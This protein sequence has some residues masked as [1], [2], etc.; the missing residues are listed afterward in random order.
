M[1]YANKAIKTIAVCLSI[2]LLVA[3]HYTVSFEG[4]SLLDTNGQEFGRLS[5][6]IET[7]D[8]SLYTP[9]RVSIEPDI[10]EVALSGSMDVFPTETTTYTMTVEAHRTDGTEWNTSITTTVYIGPRVDYSKFTDSKLKACAE[11]TGYTHIEQFQSLLCYD[12]EIRSLRG[13]EQLTELTYLGVDYNQI[14]NFSP[15]ASLEKLSTLSASDNGISSV[16]AFPLIDSLSSLVLSNN[17]IADPSPLSALTNLDNLALDHNAISSAATLSG[18]T[19][20][21]SLFLQYNDIDDVT[22]LSQLTQL[23]ALSLQANGIRYGV[24]SLKSLTNIAALDMRDNH[25]VSCLQ[26]ATLFLYLGSALLT[27]GCK[28]P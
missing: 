3:C 14:T 20:L 1:H 25:E 7:T 16:S 23:Q 2:L 28:F 21:T 13:I 10:G 9:D 17:N 15:L 24:P 22:N 8:G 18:F 12:K 19:G 26:Y 27:D 6:T 5:W 11:E 4:E